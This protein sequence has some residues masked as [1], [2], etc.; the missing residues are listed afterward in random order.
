MNIRSSQDITI[1]HFA[2]QNYR[3]FLSLLLLK[4]EYDHKWN[5]LLDI[6]IRSG[7]LATPLHFAVIFRQLKNVEL[8]LKY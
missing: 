6:N 1:V 8:L 5:F 3:G 4:E 7:L 2:A